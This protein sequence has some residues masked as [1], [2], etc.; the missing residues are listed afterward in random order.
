MNCILKGVSVG[1]V[2]KIL[3]CIV[4]FTVLLQFSCT[5]ND[6]ANFQDID[7][8][9]RSYEV[10]GWHLHDVQGISAESPVSTTGTPSQ[11]APSRQPS[12]VIMY[13]GGQIVYKVEFTETRH[14]TL[15]VPV[16]DKDG[17]FGALIYRKE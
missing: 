5:T 16:V 17:V 4:L 9:S 12:S 1:M 15:V 11:I 3:Y 10:T 2:L 6:S 14:E 13:D 7:N 8:I